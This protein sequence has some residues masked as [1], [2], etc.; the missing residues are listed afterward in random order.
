MQDYVRNSNELVQPL[1]G[2]EPAAVRHP[3]RRR[4][5]RTR[6]ST[7]RTRRTPCKIDSATLADRAHNLDVPD[8]LSKAQN[9]FV[10]ALELRRDALSVIAEEL[11]KATAQ[12]ARRQSTARI[13]EHDAGLPRAAT[14]SMQQPL[15]ARGDER[16]E[17]RERLARRCPACRR[18]PSSRTSQWLQPNFVADQISGISG[19]AAAR[20]TPGLHGDGLGHRVARRR[21]AHAGRLDHGSADQGHRVRRP[22]GEPGRQHR[23]RRGR[24]GHGGLRRRR[25]QARGDDPGDRRRRAED[26]EHPADLPAARPART[27]RSR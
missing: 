18:S 20:A 27:S 21:G 2:R 5:T 8:Q 6:T 12:Q 15:P 3:R 7:A 13:A 26:G 1:E 9:Y 10:E 4:A 19:S 22:G 23:D 14:C 24:D 17:E 16:A 25:D 11:P